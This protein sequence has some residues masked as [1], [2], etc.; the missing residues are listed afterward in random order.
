MPVPYLRRKNAGWQ[1]QIR[2]PVTLDPSLCLSPIRLTIP[3]MPA[4]EAR[5]KA[6]SVVSAVQT[7][8]A[9]VERLNEHSPMSP[10]AARDATMDRITLAIPMLVGLDALAAPT[11]TTDPLLI[12]RVFDV[13]AQIGYDRVRGEGA[14]ADPRIRHEQIYAAALQVPQIASAATRDGTS[15]TEPHPI[16]ELLAQSGRIAELTN[17]L[18]TMHS[19]GVRPVGEGPLFSEV[20]KRQIAEIADR[21]GPKSELIGIYTKVGKEFMAIV[22]DRPI[23][24]YRRTDLQEYANEIAWLPPTASSGKGYRHENVKTYIARNKKA[25][26]RGLAAKSIRDGRISHLKAIIGRGCEDNDQQNRVANTRVRVP[27][28]A[29]PP[30][31]HKAPEPHA[32]SRVLNVA[33]DTEG[34]TIPLMLALGALTGR[35]VSLL[36]TLRREALVRWHDVYVIEVETHRYENGVWIRVP[37]KTD[38]SRQCIVVPNALVEA[39]IVTWAQQEPGPMF[40]EFMACEDPGDAA[41]KKVNRSIQKITR[42]HDLPHFTYHGLRGGRIDDALDNQMAAHLV[43]H[44]VGHK[45][46]SVHGRYRSLTPKQARLIACQPLPEGVDWSCLERLDF[47]AP[48]TPTRKRRTSEQLKVVRARRA[49]SK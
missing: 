49:R 25:Q 24:A 18:T 35:R 29:S 3:A 33:V 2:L 23:G 39:G 16:D 47:S 41:Q 4:I 6:I 48:Q 28:R 27:D 19:I 12:D 45:A 31:K 9:E 22:G 14:F 40:P 43:Q 37:F 46:D 32:L 34:L 13:L 42:Q 5:R 15:S 38:E 7:A 10:K 26:G 11:A 8:I 20:L 36:A 30:V 1:V 44:Q 17:A 21:K